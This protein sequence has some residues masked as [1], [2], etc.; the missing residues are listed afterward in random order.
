VNQL[1]KFIGKA[2][3]RTEPVTR[4]G[5][6]DRS[7]MSRPVFI[8]KVD[9]AVAYFRYPETYL[10]GLHILPADLCDEHWQE[11][12]GSWIRENWPAPEVIS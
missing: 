3:I 9:R 2:I 7:F 1:E 5:Y 11:V 12:D 8:E 4:N 10:K 6:V